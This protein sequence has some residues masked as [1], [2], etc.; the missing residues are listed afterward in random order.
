M[1]NL[2]FLWLVLQSMM[3]QGLE[4]KILQLLDRVALGLMIRFRQINHPGLT[5]LILLHLG[6]NNRDLHTVLHGITTMKECGMNR[7]TQD[8]ITSG[9]PLGIT[10]QILLGTT[11]LKHHGTTSTSSLHGEGA[12]GN[13][14]FECS[15]HLTSEAHSLHISNIPSSISPHIHII[16]TASHLASCRMTSHLAIPLKGRLILIVLTTPKGTFLKKLDHLIIILGIDCLTLELVSILLGVGHST[17]ILGLL[18]MDLMG[19]LLTCGDKAPL[20]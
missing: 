18:H 20:T 3:Q 9:R 14:H 15:G 8:G 4:C 10:S 19:S 5:S 11:N 12:K 1:A 13:L 2:S 6:V 17:L 16:S 7:E